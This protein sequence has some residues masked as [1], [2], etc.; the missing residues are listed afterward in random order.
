MKQLIVILLLT[1]TPLFIFSQNKSS[2]SINWLDLSKAEVLIKEKV[3]LKKE[4]LSRVAV[5]REFCDE[6]A[7]QSYES[8]MASG[9]P[10]AA[11]MAQA[12][13][14]RANA[15]EHFED[16]VADEEN[17]ADELAQR[18]Y[19]QAVAMGMPQVASADI[20]PLLVDSENFIVPFV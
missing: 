12:Q 8:A 6:V 19:E 13:Y 11:A 2:E 10:Y 16:A 5:H 18:E 1:I 7:Q 3:G 17:Y 9:L 20:R 15:V 14:A 4:R